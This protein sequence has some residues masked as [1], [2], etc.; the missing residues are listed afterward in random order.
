MSD[1]VNPM[2]QSPI[3]PIRLSEL[4]FENQPNRPLGA[5][6]D[7]VREELPTPKRDMIKALT[8]LPSRLDKQ[9][10]SPTQR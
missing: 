6:S 8:L 4:E 7:F 9:A 1:I 5:L 3:Q 2:G 10:L